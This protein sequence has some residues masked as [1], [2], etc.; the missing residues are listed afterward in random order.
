MPMFMFSFSMSSTVLW[1]RAPRDLRSCGYGLA[2]PAPA[3][4]AIKSFVFWSPLALL[5][6]THLRMAW[7]SKLC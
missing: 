4:A 1:Q 2:Y 7:V 6:R 5:L 3:F